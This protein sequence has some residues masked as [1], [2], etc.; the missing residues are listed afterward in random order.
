M[1]FILNGMN[2]NEFLVQLNG[3]AIPADGGSFSLKDM[4]MDNIEFENGAWKCK[5]C[6]KISKSQSTAKDHGE[7]H[8]EG[9]TYPCIEC[10]K[11]YHTSPSLRQ[12]LKIKHKEKRYKESTL[13][14]K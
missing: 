12:H 7:I 2:L 6:G 3:E 10:N 4:L 13:D 14:E 8:I 11:S 9:L 5:V 1:S